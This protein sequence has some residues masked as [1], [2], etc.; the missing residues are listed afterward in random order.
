MR[1][2]PSRLEKASSSSR[3]RQSTLRSSRG[4]LQLDTPSLAQLLSMGKFLR[5]FSSSTTD[6]FV[7]PEPSPPTPPSCELSSTPP[8]PRPAPNLSSPRSSGPTSRA[9]TSHATTTFRFLPPCTP[10]GMVGFQTVLRGTAKPWTELELLERAGRHF[11][12]ALAFIYSS[13]NPLTPSHTL[14]MYSR[15]AV[16]PFLSV[17]ESSQLSLTSP[18]FDSPPPVELLARFVGRV[19]PTRTTLSIRR[20]VLEEPFS[21]SS[22][23]FATLLQVPTKLTSVFRSSLGR[24]W[25]GCVEGS[26]RGMG[27][28]EREGVGGAECEIEF[29]NGWLSK[30]GGE[31]EGVNSDSNCNPSLLVSSLSCRTPG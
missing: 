15:E 18:R 26:F 14:R 2:S 8:L 3:P 25:D 5:P 1:R 4:L 7:G 16:R 11:R 13:L 12:R 6:L 28:R 19:W 31:L 17:P 29:K 30:S 10:P 22:V 27:L 24:C 20:A 23:R 21:R 9:T